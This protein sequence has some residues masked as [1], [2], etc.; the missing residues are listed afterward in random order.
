MTGLF[1]ALFVPLGY[2]SPFWSLTCVTLATGLVMLLVFGKVSNQEGIRSAKGKVQ[3]GL[4]ATRLFQND[5]SVFFRIQGRMALDILVYM[6]HSVKPMLIMAVP[7][8]LIL[9]QLYGHYGIR[10]LQAGES[11]LVKASVAGPSLLREAAAVRLQTAED[12]EIETAAVRI[13][14]KG[15]VAWRIRP[16]KEGVFT[17]HVEAGDERVSKSLVAGK[18]RR[19]LSGVRTGEGAL[20]MLLN[21]GEAPIRSPAIRSIE[22][23]YPPMDISLGRWNVHW[24]VYFFIFSILSGYLCKGLFGI[25]I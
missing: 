24:L 12:V 20:S 3:G 10:P 22:V 7:V 16:L 21:P 15:E 8:I 11:V 1:D 13:P 5:L 2:L 23:L 14:S 18:S 4:I 6:K 9:I 17:F 25:Q 19:L